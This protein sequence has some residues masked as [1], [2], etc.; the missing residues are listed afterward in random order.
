M[1]TARLWATRSTCPKRAVGACITTKDGR[2]IGVGYNGAPAKL[3][4]CDEDSCDL[5]AEGDCTRAVHAEANAIAVAA[6]HGIALKGMTMFITCFPCPRCAQLI[7]ASGIDTIIYDTPRRVADEIYNRT[8]SI[9]HS[10]HIVA[11][12][13]GGDEEWSSE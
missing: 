10:G 2:P 3:R 5:D 11:S 12:R 13:Y 6:K 7:V 9:L 8:W 1:D 4:H